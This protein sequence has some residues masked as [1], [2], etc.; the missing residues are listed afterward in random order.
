MNGV[1]PMTGS[2]LLLQAFS[3]DLPEFP[4]D[5]NRSKRIRGGESLQELLNP[6]GFLASITGVQRA[7]GIAS[8]PGKMGIVDR[9]LAAPVFGALV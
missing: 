7:H 3:C 2:I 1:K 9:V 5:R 8:L 6:C 4:G